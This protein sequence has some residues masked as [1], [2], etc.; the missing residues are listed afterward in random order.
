MSKGELQ[1]IMKR[2][3]NMHTSLYIDRNAAGESEL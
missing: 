1:G 3:Q 2:M